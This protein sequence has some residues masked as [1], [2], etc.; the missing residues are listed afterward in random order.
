MKQLQAGFLV[1]PSLTTMVLLLW[2][3]CDASVAVPVVLDV[4]GYGTYYSHP[5]AHGKFGKSRLTIELPGGV[6]NQLAEFDGMDISAIHRIDL[7]G[8]GLPELLLILKNQFSND[9]QPCIFQESPHF[10]ILYPVSAVENPITGKD[11]SLRVDETGTALVVRLDVNIHDFGP[12]SLIKRE[13]YRLTSKGLEKFQEEFEEGEHFNTKM[14]LAGLAFQ[15]GRFHEALQG[16]SDLLA[17]FEASMPSDAVSETL[18]Y[19]ARSRKHLKDFHGAVQLFQ[20][21]VI[22][23]PESRFTESAQKKA[24]FLSLHCD[25]S[26]ILGLYID[27]Q[28]LMERGQ[29][30][31]VIAMLNEKDSMVSGSDFLLMIK[32]EARMATGRLDE[33]ILIFTEIRE[34]FPDSHLLDDVEQLLEELG[35]DPDSAEEM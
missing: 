34:N 26:D 20:K 23:Y 35:G 25:S 6:V 8:D 17:S 9:L 30:D 15:H 5:P 3:F 2:L 4:P 14:N 18:Y 32:G 10:A 7:N 28:L 31:H 13:F 24:E 12:P 11:I 16:Y 19:M 22:N 27:L 33:A 21:L 29:F 1:Q